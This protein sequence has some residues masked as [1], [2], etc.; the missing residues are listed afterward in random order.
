MRE[1][2]GLQVD[3]YEP[4]FSYFAD[5]VLWSF[6]AIPAGLHSTKWHSIGSG[7]RRLVDVYGP[8]AKRPRRLD[9]F[10]DIARENASGQ[11][12]GLAVGALNC[13][14]NFLEWHDTYHRA[15]DLPV[16]HLHTE[17]DIRQNRRLYNRA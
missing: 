1:P 13:F 16:P 8:E 11:T 7:T 9:C 17:S 6:K 4:L 15:K 3:G 10:I 12:I 2:V 14:L 5:R